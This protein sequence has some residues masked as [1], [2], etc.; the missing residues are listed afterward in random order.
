MA[1]NMGMKY[2]SKTSNG[3]CRAQFDW[4]RDFSAAI[5]CGFTVAVYMPLLSVLPL[6]MQS[7]LLSMWASKF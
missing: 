7:L 2:N 5:T 1:G 3:A 6:F 4:E